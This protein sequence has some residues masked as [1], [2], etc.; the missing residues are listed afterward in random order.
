LILDSWE[1]GQ[2]G[3]RGL[4]LS[5]SSKFTCNRLTCNS[6][7]S[8]ECTRKKISHLAYDLEFI[9][10]KATFPINTEKI[11]NATYYRAYANTHA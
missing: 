6:M 11:S 3:P 9:I 10:K 8:S 7:S 1:K 5:G 2:K 4:A